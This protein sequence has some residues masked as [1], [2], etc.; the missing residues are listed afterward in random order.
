MKR[1]LGISLIFALA[2]CVLG[3]VSASAEEAA[4]SSKKIKVFIL[5]GQSGMAGFGRSHEL[6]DALRK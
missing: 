3:V 1:L 4:P 5:S 6:P 2:S